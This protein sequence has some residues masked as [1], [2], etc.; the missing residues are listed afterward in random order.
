VHEEGVAAVK[1]WI[2][3]MTEARGYPPPAP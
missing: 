1:A 3:S 2:E